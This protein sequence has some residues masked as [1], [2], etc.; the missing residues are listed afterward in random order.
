MW[1]KEFKYDEKTEKL[2]VSDEF[3]SAYRLFNVNYQVDNIR[4]LSKSEIFI[5]LLVCLDKHDEE[6]KVVMSNFEKFKEEALLIHKVL[7]ND[8]ADDS[9]LKHLVDTLN[10]SYVNVA[11]SVV[12]KNGEK[13]PK[14]YTKD[15]ATQKMRDIKITLITK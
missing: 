2:T 10:K 4:K 14:V 7:E 12:D 13:L 5:M 3:I 9:N 15:E 11:D 8:V 6:Q 1:E